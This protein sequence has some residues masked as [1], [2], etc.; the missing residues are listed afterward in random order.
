[1]QAPSDDYFPDVDPTPQNSDMNPVAPAK[2]PDADGTPGNSVVPV[3]N[4]DPSVPN[5]ITP[6]KSEDQI[7]VDGLVNVNTAPWPVLARVP[8]VVPTA[9]PFNQFSHLVTYDSV[10]D[11]ATA[12]NPRNTATTDDNVSLAKAIVNY[13]NKNGPF[14]SLFDLYKVPA[15]RIVNE[16][17]L[18]ANASGPLDGV[19]SPYGIGLTAATPGPGGNVRYNFKE[20]YLLLNHVSNLLT[21]RSDTFTCYIYLQGWRNANTSQPTLAVQRRAAIIIDRSAVTPTNPT[22]LNFKI[23]TE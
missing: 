16:Q 11:I 10:S 17:L 3:A 9:T 12:A 5:D 6:G 20:R 4:S 22:P 7:G 21:T 2:Y 14:K 1:M 15:F 19:F 8:F 23:S 18:T 13:R